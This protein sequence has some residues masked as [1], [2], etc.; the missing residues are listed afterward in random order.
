MPELISVIGV[1]I[2]LIPAS[3]LFFM[4]VIDM[5]VD[6]MEQT[7]P[8][9]QKLRRKNYCKECG[10]TIPRGKTYCDSCRRKRWGL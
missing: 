10:V 6:F 7:I 8:K 1:V 4:M 5:A 2:L 3:L 9:I